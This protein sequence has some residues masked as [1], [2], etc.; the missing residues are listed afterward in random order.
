MHFRE[1]NP[2]KRLLNHF[3]YENCYILCDVK[4][5]VDQTTNTWHT[6]H[7]EHLR[8]PY[9]VINFSMHFICPISTDSPSYSHF[10]HCSLISL[11]RQ[12]R[13]LLTLEGTNIKN[14][15]NSFRPK[16]MNSETYQPNKK[17]IIFKVKPPF[18]EKIWIF[19]CI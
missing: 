2:S 3:K 9:C 10:L 11:L 14:F 5:M 1:I 13:T 7:T 16:W 15:T 6:V 18:K 4:T 12:E 8:A 17:F 19:V